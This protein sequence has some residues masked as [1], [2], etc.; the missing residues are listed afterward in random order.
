MTRPV[1]AGMLRRV[2]RNTGSAKVHVTDLHPDQFNAYVLFGSPFVGAAMP[3]VTC[4]GA[5]LRGRGAVVCME[6]GTPVHCPA[7]KRFTGVEHAA[8]DN[9]HHPAGYTAADLRE[10]AGS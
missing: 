9:N 4:C 1:P 6:P 8:P 5:V 10:Q 7:C 2:V 3:V